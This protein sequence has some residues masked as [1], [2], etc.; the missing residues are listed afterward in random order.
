MKFRWVPWYRT[1]FE[2]DETKVDFMRRVKTFV[3]CD[4]LSAKTSDY[5]GD[6]DGDGF[7]I[8]F[9]RLLHKYSLIQIKE[10]QTSYSTILWGRVV[11][12]GEKCEIEIIISIYWLGYIIFLPL[13]VLPIIGFIGD[14]DLF[15]LFFSVLIYGITLVAF[16]LRAHLLYNFFLKILY[17]KPNF[18]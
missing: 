18:Y 15:N 17:N 8:F 3:C 13:F 9:R 7:R 14:G 6:V 12:R 1:T 11:E 16:N 4:D 5:I 10:F 2:I